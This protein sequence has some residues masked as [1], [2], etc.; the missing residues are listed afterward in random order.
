M[1]V[2]DDSAISL[3]DPNGVLYRYM[4]SASDMNTGSGNLPRGN[5][6]YTAIY[7]VV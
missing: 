1:P 7:L 2:R 4:S 6:P 5:L 3:V